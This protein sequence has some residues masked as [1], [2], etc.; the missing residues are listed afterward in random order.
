MS[1]VLKRQSV[2][3]M[4]QYFKSH[5][6]N[7]RFYSNLPAIQEWLNVLPASGSE[8]DSYPLE[9]T[10]SMLQDKAELRPSASD[11]CAKIINAKNRVRGEDVLFVDG[12][13][14]VKLTGIRLPR[15]HPTV[16]FGPR[17]WTKKS[18]L[19]HRQSILVE[20]LQ[21]FYSFERFV[22]FAPFFAFLPEGESSKR[23]TRC[24]CR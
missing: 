12:A 5:P 15:A 16:T 24:S 6:D 8:L 2:D 21:K 22:F 20:R 18:R 11:L 3:A 4:H 13:A 14:P 10:A 23:A 1:T 7:Y 9:R 19:P 17:T